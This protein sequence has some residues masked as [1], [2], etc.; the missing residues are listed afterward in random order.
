MGNAATLT[1]RGDHSAG[2]RG[3]WRAPPLSIA[4]LR[5]YQAIASE[6]RSLPGEAFDAAV[7]A[8]AHA[9]ASD[10]LGGQLAPVDLQRL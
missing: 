6:A 10:P 5:R 8:H 4:L 3:P 1:D 9:A 2:H 7:E